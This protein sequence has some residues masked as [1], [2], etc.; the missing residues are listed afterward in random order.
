MM[1]QQEGNKAHEQAQ[2]HLCT[3]QSTQSLGFTV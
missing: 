1:K 3:F 2:L